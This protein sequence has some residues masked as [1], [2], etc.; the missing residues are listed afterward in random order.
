M[1][2]LGETISGADA[3]FTAGT[4]AIIYDY[5]LKLNKGDTA[6]AH[7][8]AEA[9]VERVAQP[10]RPGTRSLY[11]NTATNPLIRISWSFASE[12]RQKLALAVYNLAT[13]TLSQKARAL[14]VTW[15]FGGVMATLIRAVMAD[16]RDSDDDEFFDDK[17]WDPVRLTLM[18]TTG[19]FAGLPIL[20]DA[21]ES[22]IFGAA[23]KYLPEGNMFSAIPRSVKGLQNL[24]DWF[25]GD[26]EAKDM[27]QDLQAI[28]YGIA[29]FSGTASATTSATNILRD[30]LEILD[31]LLAE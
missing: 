11:E 23:G 8:A 17:N 20:G 29:P 18:A 7:A 21:L 19:P 25:T 16:I 13:G 6:A 4:Y 5:Q 30:A 27:T 26:R 31:N 14:A 12:S 22:A 28:L 24:P 15:G 9:G 1:Q 10:T 3:L 2:K